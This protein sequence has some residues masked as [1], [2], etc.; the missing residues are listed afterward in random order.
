MNRYATTP[1]DADPEAVPIR[2]AATVMIVDDRPEL[3]VLM[4]QRTSRAVF[5]PTAW[6]FPGGRVDPDDTADLSNV[7][8]GLSDAAASALLQVAAK[9]RAWWFAGMRETLEEAGLLLGAGG[10]DSVAVEAIRD[11][12]FADAAS[13]AGALAER[14]VSLDL[15]VMAEVA[16]FITP[17][18][19]PRRFDTRFF[20]AQAPVG[21]V[22]AHDEEEVVEHRWVSPA[23]AIDAWRA[24]DFPM[25]SVTHRMLAC[26]A[27]YRDAAAVIAA[28]GEQRPA[29]RV[30]VDD[31]DGEYRVLLPGDSGY[32][33]AD[34]EIEHGWVRI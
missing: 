13:F 8:H 22:A 4:V 29:D 11:A 34:L 5:A 21:Q 32:E 1:L 10:A 33:N 15:S 2:H 17:I 23:G 26:L 14:S 30:R 28:A 6:V 16:R 27:R 19:P 3:S 25:M 31:P 7:V 12:V 24:G 18:G 20:L 9:G